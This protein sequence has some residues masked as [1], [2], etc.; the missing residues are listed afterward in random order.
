LGVIGYFWNYFSCKGRMVFF[1]IFYLSL[2]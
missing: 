1:R 2:F